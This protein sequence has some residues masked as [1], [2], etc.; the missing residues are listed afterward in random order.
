MSA[1]SPPRSAVK[2]IVIV[3]PRSELERLEGVPRLA[4]IESFRVVHQLR[5]NSQMMAGI[6]E[7]K[8][9]TAALTPDRMVGHAGLEKV[10]TLA[11]LGEGAYVAYFEGR[12][13][14]GWAKLATSTGTHLLPPFELT[15]KNWRISVLGTGSQLRRFLAQLRRLKV[16]YRV[17]T[18]GGIDFRTKS[19][20]GALT[21]KQREV[22][23]TAYRTGYYEV[24]RRGD[25][26]QV[27]KTVHL[28]KSTT[29]EH[30]R[31]AEKRLLERILSDEGAVAGAIG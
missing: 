17:Q 30:L 10:Q 27:A 7:V 1:T 12:P 19:L 2:R 28:G 9:R 20:L 31:K 24:P 13:T 29:V 5:F 6:C 25:S 26:A 18:I 8:F 21:V 11:T 15:P 14:V 23:L 3:S 16:H 4:A 22:L